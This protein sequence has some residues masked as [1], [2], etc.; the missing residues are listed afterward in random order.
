MQCST[1]G[2]MSVKERGIIFPLPLLAVLLSLHP[3]M[4]LV[5]FAA[6]LVHVECA[7]YQD[8]RVLFPRPVPQ[9][10]FLQSSSLT[11]AGFYTY[12]C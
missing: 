11:G 2:P 6:W 7:A 12:P 10:V 4:L 1:W 5:G 9:P 8:L 3:T